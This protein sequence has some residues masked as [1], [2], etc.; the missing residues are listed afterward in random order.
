MEWYSTWSADRSFGGLDPQDPWFD[1]DHGSASYQVTAGQLGITG[2]TP[3]MYVRDPAK[4]RQWRNVEVTMYFKRM[5]DTGV[6]YAGMVAVARTNHSADNH[7]CD[8]RGVG[9]RLR[10]DG[11]VDFEKE[12]SH[13]HNEA[14]AAKV[15]WPGGMPFGRWIGYKYIV[16]DLP[17]GSVKL[18]IWVDQTGGRNGGKW[19]KVNQVVD[20]G[21]LFGDVP[22]APGIDPR[23]PLTASPHRVGS[24]SGK[25]NL[26]V[27]FRSDGVRA[28]GLLYKWGSIREIKPPA[29]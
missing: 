19:R 5:S 18:E 23:M 20:N 27:Y 24:E 28:G 17:G 21:K 13:P 26:N 7:P 12:T 22:C 11:R 4:Q 1:A 10:Y 3:R 9:G 6:P 2:T 25:P 15:L 29:G 14:T 8:T 16:Y